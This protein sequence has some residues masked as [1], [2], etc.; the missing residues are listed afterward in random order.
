MGED[1][2]AKEFKAMKGRK[3]PKYSNTGTDC[4]WSI[5][6][7]CVTEYFGQRFYEGFLVNF[8]KFKKGSSE[9]LI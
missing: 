5:A 2:R 3:L 6:P 4:F 7:E 8:D 9:I 1:T